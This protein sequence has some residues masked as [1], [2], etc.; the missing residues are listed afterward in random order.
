M[1]NEKYKFTETWKSECV[2]A[3]LLFIPLLFTISAVF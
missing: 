2:L 3:V 1:K